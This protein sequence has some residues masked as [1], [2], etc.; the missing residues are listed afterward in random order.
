MTPTPASTPSE[1]AI[2]VTGEVFG[3]A[4]AWDQSALR[5]IVERGAETAGCE[6]A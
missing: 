1:P 3:N 2:R 4:D 5:A 6:R